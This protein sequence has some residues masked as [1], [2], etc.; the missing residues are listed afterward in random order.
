[1]FVPPE[2][3]EPLREKSRSRDRESKANSGEE[4]EEEEELEEE[5]GGICW[6]LAHMGNVRK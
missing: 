1:M 4:E 5:E 3:N 6:E 2:R